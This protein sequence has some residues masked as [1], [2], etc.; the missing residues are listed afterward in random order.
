MNLFEKIL[1]IIVN[2]QARLC[3]I[4]IE[5]IGWLTI[6]TLETATPGP[7]RLHAS[8]RSLLCEF[9]C[10]LHAQLVCWG[11]RSRVEP[12]TGAT[13]SFVKRGQKTTLGDYFL[14]RIFGIFFGERKALFWRVFWR[15]VARPAAKP[16]NP[17]ACGHWVMYGDQRSPSS[18]SGLGIRCTAHFFEMLHVVVRYLCKKHNVSLE[19]RDSL[20]KV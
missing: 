2:C 20:L 6:I 12:F 14:K 16:P 1:K 10:G 17:S 7:C 13:S 15:R 5:L 9:P 3:T 18:V 4:A 11:H 8:V 19:L